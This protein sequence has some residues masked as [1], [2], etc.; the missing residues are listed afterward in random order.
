[1]ME[2]LLSPRLRKLLLAAPAAACLLSFSGASFAADPWPTRPIK[3]VVPY[4][5]GG[6]TDVLARLVGQKLSERIGQTVVIENKSGAG[7]NIGTD[8]VAKSAPDGYTLTM[9]NIGP[10][11]INPSLYP[12]L[13]YDP[14]KDLAPITF[15]V[16]VPNLLLV[17]NALPVKNVQEF[18]DYVRA[19]PGTS[20]AS[21]GA[22]TSLHLSGELFVATAGVKMTHVPYR[23][24]APALA[25]LMAGHVPALF[26]N[27]FPA[28]TQ[29]KA[30][31][32]RA[33]AITSAQRSEHLPDVPTLAESGLPGYDV[34]GWFGI[35]APAGTPRPVITRLHQEF[36]AI[37][38]MPDVRKRITDF[39][40][41]ISGAGPDE[42]R[43]FIVS[44]TAKWRKL[45]QTQN[46]KV[47]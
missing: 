16:S 43:T 5:A 28:I 41:M 3:L 26:D 6:S 7:G 37:L 24:G 17:N 23:G 30:G 36:A 4:P 15:L 11:A 20:Y 1:M 2:K 35:L 12:N 19:R 8:S 33:I 38:Q 40:G 32:V 44:E 22:G 45:V 29:V 14:L 34:T 47:Q 27:M 13:P 25:D 46:I 9:G 39:G 31:K 21:P 18:V 10:I 42:F